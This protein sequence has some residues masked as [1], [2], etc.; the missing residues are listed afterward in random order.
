MR[1]PD[2][3]RQVSLEN[4]LLREKLKVWNELRAEVFSGLG[5][6]LSSQFDI[7]LDKSERSVLDLLEDTGLKIADIKCEK[8]TLLDNALDK[9]KNG[10]YGICEDCGKEIIEARLQVF[11]YAA[12]CAICQLRRESIGKATTHHLATL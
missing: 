5:N 11:P 7:P 12:C 3:E 1:Q 9:L 10:R 2:D 6:D 4:L 8:L